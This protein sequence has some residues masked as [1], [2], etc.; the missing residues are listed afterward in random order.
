MYE[1][2]QG[3]NEM[4]MRVPK[5]AEL[6]RVQL[7]GYPMGGPYE[8]AFQFRDGLTVIC[9]NGDGW[10]HVSVSRKSKMPS[11]EDMDRIKRLFWDDEDLVMQLHMPVSEH[12]NFHPFTLHMWRPLTA[13]IPQPPYWMVGPRAFS[14]GS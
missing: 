11:Y 2:T 3:E 1:G 5:E 12:I 8:G 13:R 14:W 4:T 7:P 9:S 6:Y 10:E